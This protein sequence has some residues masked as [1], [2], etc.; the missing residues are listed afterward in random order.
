M[1]WIAIPGILLAV[2]IILIIRARRRSIKGSKSERKYF[3][4]LSE[5]LGLPF[6][7]DDYF[8]QLEGMWN[9]F[10]VII[11]P[12]HFE[13]PGSVI[14]IYLQTQIPIIQRNWIEPNLSL[15]RALV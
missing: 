14:L 2:V 11:L 1:R 3:R 7:S 15:G 8:V 9:G 13:G 10:P 4:H 5:L 12:H 6:V